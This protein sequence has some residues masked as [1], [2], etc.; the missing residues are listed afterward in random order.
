[1][2][3]LETL[4]EELAAAVNA[5]IKQ[6]VVT[7]ADFVLPPDPAMADLSLACFKI[8]QT[9]KE[10]PVGL[11][12]SIAKDFKHSA[13]ATVSDAGAYVNFAFN[14]SVCS[15]ILPEILKQGH[16]YGSNNLG[17]KRRVMQEFGN[18]NTHKEVHIGHLRNIAFGDAVNRILSAN[19][20]VSIPVA[21]I[22]DFGIH[23]AKTLWHYLKTKAEAPKDNKGYFL[24]Q[25]YTASVKAMENDALAKMEVGEVMK[26]IESRRGDTYKLWKKTRQWSIDQWNAVN[27]ELGVKLKTTFYES[28]FI[29]DGL[30]MVKQL[31]AHGI[32]V[33]SQ[34]AVIADLEKYGL[35]VLVVL[36]SDGTALYPVAD[37]PLTFHKVK[38]YKLDTSLW[39]VD[40][41]QTQYLDQLFKVLELAGLKARLEHLPYE[42]V[43]L[44]SGMMSSRSGNIISYDDLK[45]QAIAQALKETTQRHPD[46][47]AAKLEYVAETLAFAALKFEMVKVSGDKVITFDIEKALR[48]DGFTA[49]YV[50][51]AYARIQS[52]LRKASARQ[53]T[54]DIDYGFLEDARERRLA[55]TLARFPQVVRQAGESYQPME[56]ARYVYDLAQQFND[57]YHAVPILSASDVQLRYIKARLDLTQAVARVLENGLKLLGIEVLNEM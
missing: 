40:K 56:I 46:W 31:K 14:S 23:T 22:N 32:L 10:N 2:Y 1:M 52:L 55:L 3:A 13:V 45:S 4:K 54:A 43:K 51:Y 25:L 7:A 28:D 36:R 57:F 48:F 6:P 50:Q 15:K 53:L 19:G 44:P 24:G 30:K 42:F 16:G 39:V 34:G 41:R 9:V 49:A 17:K 12:R 27:K 26:A 11:A 47:K 5:L 8:A 37:L 33:D 35:G 38:K 29:D 20:Y 18:G 21:Y